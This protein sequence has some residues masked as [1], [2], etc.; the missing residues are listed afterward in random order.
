M[1]T[2]TFDYVLYHSLTY[3]IPLSIVCNYIAPLKLTQMTLFLWSNS[4]YFASC[5]NSIDIED[6]LQSR[7]GLDYTERLWPGASY[8]EQILILIELY[9]IL[10]Y[11]WTCFVLLLLIILHFYFPGRSNP[12]SI[13]SKET[14]AHNVSGEYQLVKVFMRSLRRIIRPE[15]R[16][17]FERIE[18]TCVSAIIIPTEHHEQLIL[19]HRI[20]EKIYFSTWTD[21]V[22]NPYENS[23]TS[24]YLLV[25]LESRRLS[26]VS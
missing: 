14:S 24:L 17:G 13:F 18:W 9:Y 20:V 4:C 16:P 1:A 22:L 5:R 8:V 10:Q 26:Q 3:I 15:V 6:L 11:S 19:I 21:P 7:K 12:K 2:H 25:E 23:K